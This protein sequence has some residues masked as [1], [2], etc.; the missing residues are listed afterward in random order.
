MVLEVC[1]GVLGNEADAEDAVQATF[2]ILAWK[3]HS[4]RKL[5]SVASWLHGVAYRTALKAR[6][7]NARR[8]RHEDGAARQEAIVGSGNDL[9]WREFRQ[10][11]H[12]ELNCLS[13]RYRTPLVLCYLEG[14]TLEE[15]AA[16][17]G[18]AKGTLKGHLERGRALLR[19]RLVRR[20]FGPG[21]A[22]AVAAWPGATAMA[23]VP[24]AIV[25][26]TVQAATQVAL[27][28]AAT[29]AVSAKVAGLAEGV[30]STMFLTK[31]KGAT[32]VLLL[33]GVLFTG[34]S[35]ILTE[36]LARSVP[37]QKSDTVLVN[38][39]VV[40]DEEAAAK[41]N[42]AL[43]SQKV[44]EATWMLTE[45]DNAKDTISV[46]TPATGG[47]SKIGFT[48]RE[49]KGTERVPPVGGMSWMLTEVDKAKD[50]ISVTT[51]A[52]GGNSKIGVRFR[53]VKG[54]ERVP[55]V[56]GMS[57]KG[58]SVARTAMIQLDGKKAKLSELK[59]GMRV[60]LQMSKDS[61][62]IGINALREQPHQNEYTVKAVDAIKNTITVTMGKAG[63]SL[64]GVPV[65]KDAKI[66]AYL[67]NFANDE[68]VSEVLK[69]SDVQAGMPVRLEMAVD[70]GKLVV[71]AM[72][73][74]DLSK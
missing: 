6:A 1:R 63:P 46:T 3:A 26:S 35:L 57:L 37:A 56:G 13:E 33:V 55:P 17:L 51:P 74:G 12:E 42:E 60:S 18:L 24:P 71:K 22:L 10:V 7:D 67:F 29:A 23:G 59:A 65:A 2:L 50:T 25:A 62:T 32:A 44:Q 61:L 30:T 49:V 69:L 53:E 68:I 52:T 9:T 45:V 15:A 66:L 72:Q 14:K 11:L 5:A 41:S 48:F 73:V 64:E 19:S 43:L 8:H 20:G 34:F 58:L 38:D 27:G 4:I 70:G 39:K 40:A 16:Q 31:V 36:V 21:A 47:N 54:T 28:G